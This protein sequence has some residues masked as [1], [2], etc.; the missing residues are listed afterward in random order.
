MKKGPV[1]KLGVYHDLY[2]KSDNIIT[3]IILAGVFENFRNLCLDIYQL[4][5]A[6]SSSTISMASSFKKA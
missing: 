6:K 4:D 1:K 2:L 3:T 5:P